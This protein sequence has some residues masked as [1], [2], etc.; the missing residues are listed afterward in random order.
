MDEIAPMLVAM[1]LILTIGGVVL[2]R[3]LARRLG[4]LLELMVKQRRG[5]LDNPVVERTEHLLESLSS[6]LSL[7]EERLDFTD[8]LLQER[9]DDR[10]L[11]ERVRERPR[12]PSKEADA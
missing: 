7:V 9:G 4:D 1:T 8:R 3:P 5:E 11:H 6:R 12:T 10:R 2:L